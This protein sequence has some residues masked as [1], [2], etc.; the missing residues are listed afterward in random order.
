MKGIIGFQYLMRGKKKVVI[1]ICHLL[2]RYLQ[3][4]GMY[5]RCSSIRRRNMLEWCTCYI[6]IKLVNLIC[7]KTWSIFQKPASFVQG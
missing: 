3:F 2:H 4:S 5:R 1:L 7:T 6:E